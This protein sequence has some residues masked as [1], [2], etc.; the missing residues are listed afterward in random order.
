MSSGFR[1]NDKSFGKKCYA[2][3]EVNKNSRPHIFLIFPKCLRSKDIEIEKASMIKNYHTR[4]CFKTC[5]IK[6][7]ELQAKYNESL[8]SEKYGV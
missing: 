4:F 8:K 3:L 1:L 6:L 5:A 7:I 2:R